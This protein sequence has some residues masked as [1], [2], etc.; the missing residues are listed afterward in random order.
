MENLL[1][2]YEE[3][4]I[5]GP[6]M[7]SMGQVSD[8]GTKLLQPDAIWAHTKGNG[9]KVCVIDTGCDLRHPDLQD[10]ILDS[11]DPYANDPTDKNNHG[12][13]CTGIIG[14]VDN[15]VGVIGIAPECELLIAKGLDDRGRGDWNKIAKA[16]QWAVKQGSQIINMSLGGNKRP[17]SILHDAIKWAVSKG[18]I[19]VGASGNDMAAKPGQS[20]LKQTAYPAR[21]P[22]VIAVAAVDEQGVV[23]NFSQIKGGVDL[24]APGVNIYSTWPG[25]RYARLTGTSQASPMICGAAALLKAYHGNSIAHYKDMLFH[26]QNISSG[27]KQIGKLSD[28]VG[29][30]IP[31][32]NN[33]KI[34]GLGEALSVDIDPEAYDRFES[35]DWNE[36]DK[37]YEDKVD[38]PEEEW[39]EQLEDW[40]KSPDD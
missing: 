19:I 8:W 33:V 1:F 23:T 16:V 7:L 31:N 39:E 2:P 10:N 13:H 29:P 17:P 6:T 4:V 26:L 18:V 35:H 32:F 14:A 37:Y 27:S 40:Y 12:T 21:Y 36:V 11:Y 3:E 28:E 25:G 30:G 38:S 24:A 20:S 22:E 34:K 5:D 15:E 9:V